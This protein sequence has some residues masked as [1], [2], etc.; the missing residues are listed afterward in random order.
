MHARV[1]AGVTVLVAVLAAA[2]CVDAER[3]TDCGDEEVARELQVADGRATPDDPAVCRGQDVTLR[4]ISEE[5]GILHVHGYDDELP[6]IPVVAGQT[7]EV[8][9]IAARSGQFRVELHRDEDPAG[10]EVAI[11]TVHE[12]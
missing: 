12:P 9:F 8:R 2:G 10:V 7:I 4:V 11:L 1:V 5:D 3:P 6:A